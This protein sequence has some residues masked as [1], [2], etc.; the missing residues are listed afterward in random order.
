MVK[1]LSGLI[2][3]IWSVQRIVMTMATGSKSGIFKNISD[4][5]LFTVY[6]PS[7]FQNYILIIILRSRKNR[8]KN[9]CVFNGFLN[10]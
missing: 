9:N 2:P 10:V 4:G 8:I 5:H 3:D 1:T 6:V 7:V